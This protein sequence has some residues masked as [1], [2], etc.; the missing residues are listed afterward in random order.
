[1]RG[2]AGS[3]KSTLAETIVKVCKGSV[4]YSTDEF[5]MKNGVYNYVPSRIVEAHCW[6]QERVQQAV[7]KQLQDLKPNAYDG[8]QHLPHIIV[9][10]TNIT[11]QQCQPYIDIAHSFNVGI[12]QCIPQEVIRTLSN[13]RAGQHKAALTDCAYH[14][15]RCKHP[16]PFYVIVKMMETFEDIPETVMDIIEDTIVGSTKIAID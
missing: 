5:W 1:M 12:V 16:M 10:N 4:I 6:N 9:D 7:Q 8:L 3:G 13:W 2:W 15:Y 14:W 11:L